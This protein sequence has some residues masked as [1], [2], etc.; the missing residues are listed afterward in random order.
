M[1]EI[2]KNPNWSIMVRFKRFLWLISSVVSHTKILAGQSSETVG[3]NPSAG[4]YAF[5][6]HF[7]SKNGTTS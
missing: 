3:Y 4:K 5:S 1:A 2:S 6:L 7:R